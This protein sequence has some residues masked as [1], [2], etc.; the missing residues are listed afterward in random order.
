M[1]VFCAFAALGKYAE[2][3][4]DAEATIS[5]NPSW[6]MGFSRKGAALYGLCRF[7]DA[8]ATYEAGLQVDPGNVQISQAAADV[9]QRLASMAI[10]ASVSSEET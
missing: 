8:L 9:R 7:D 3:L 2:A 4:A 1:L 10:D 6:S 5:I